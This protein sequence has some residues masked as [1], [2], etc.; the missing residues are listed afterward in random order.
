MIE[1]VPAVMPFDLD[2]LKEKMAKFVGRVPA[3]QIDLMDGQFV[4]S[5][6]WPYVQGG[7]EEFSVYKNEEDGFPY[8][9]EL[10]FSVDMMIKNPT[11]ELDDWIRAGATKL[12]VHAESTPD[13]AELID[14]L[15]DKLSKDT[16]SLGVELILA[17]NADSANELIEPHLERISGIQCM[18]I[19]KLG[20]QGEPF[21]EN[22]L[23]K[24]SYFR[25]KYPELSIRVDGGVSF[26]TAPQLISAGANV[27]VVGSILRDSDDVVRD[28]ERFKSL[29]Q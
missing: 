1:V 5:V 16:V 25:E 24:I 19:E 20:H 22:V 4:D 9:R 3:V 13:V 28:I 26:D 14:G 15:E 23:D 12:I 8:W 7:A 6:S 10:E 17:T 11:S 18:G 2:D 21:Y 27:L 29:A